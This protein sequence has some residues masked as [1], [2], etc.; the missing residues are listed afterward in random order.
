M[1]QAVKPACSG[2]HAICFTLLPEKKACRLR[3]IPPK[4]TLRLVRPSFANRYLMKAM[5]GVAWAVAE[6]GAN[7]PLI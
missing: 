4:Q 5:L 2:S 7:L 6:K 3:I 1:G